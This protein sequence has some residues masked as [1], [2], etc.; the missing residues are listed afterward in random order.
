MLSAAGVLVSSASRPLRRSLRLIEW[1]VLE[2]LALDAVDD[3]HGRL[4][5]PTS[6]RQIAEN[7]GVTPGCAAKALAGLR[8]RGLVS[9]ARQAGPAGRFGLSAY[10]L[11][12]LVGV[13][14]VIGLDPEKP[15]ARPPCSC[16]PGVAIP[17]MVDQHM[18]LAAPDHPKSTK[19]NR[20]S[21]GEQG[22]GDSHQ[23][24]L[25]SMGPGVER[26]E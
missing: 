10:R 18:S 16:S 15:D 22:V 7:L 26:N 4:V 9:H 17:H 13:E 5:V 11:S 20:R 24:D 21:S 14:V 8:S 23:L 19:R 12:P 1:V 2:E 3:G 6:A 25:L